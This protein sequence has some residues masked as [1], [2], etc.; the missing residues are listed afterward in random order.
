MTWAGYLLGTRFPELGKYLE[1]VVA[2]III[3]SIAPAVGHLLR[4][5]AKA[6]AAV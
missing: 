3:V 1:W 6:K 5:R 2:I 4:E